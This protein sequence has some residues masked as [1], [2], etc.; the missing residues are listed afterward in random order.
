MKMVPIKLDKDRILK[1]GVRA[2]VEIE[3][4]LDTTMDKV[5]FARQ[6]SIYV[7]LY[8]GLIHMD[9]KLTLDKVYDIVEKMIDECAEK[10]N[11]NFMD[12]YGKVLGEIGE[13]IGEALGETAT[14]TN[15]V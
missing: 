10:E 5:D 15:E 12:A 8:A 1:Y 9:R 2:F 13:K 11:L 3:K 7:L 6:E 4:A 14:P